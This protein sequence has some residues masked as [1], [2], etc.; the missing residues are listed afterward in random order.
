MIYI[1]KETNM[2]KIG[3]HSAMLTVGIK[4]KQELIVTEDKTA[5][6]YGSGTLE[7]FGTPAMIVFMENTA[8]KS[9]ADYIGE[10]NGT[11]GTKLNVNHVAATP[12]GMKVVCETELVK[13]E[14][15]ALTF[16]VKAYDECG[17][18]GEGTH[19]RFIIME[20]K[21]Q[22]KANSKL[23]ENEIKKCN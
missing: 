1:G 19:E 7:V 16:E 21:F 14:G 22:A 20:E 13:V 9:V 11:V 2:I 5:K 8:L 17:L 18:I 6:T 4:G 12:V 10:G 15:R 23:Q 3:E